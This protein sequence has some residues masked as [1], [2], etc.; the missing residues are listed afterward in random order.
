MPRR[1][2]RYSATFEFNQDPPLTV[3]GTTEQSQHHLAT[4]AAIQAL[5]KAYPGTRPSSLVV[6]LEF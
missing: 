5:K 2:Y 3:K 4:K 1:P 6:V